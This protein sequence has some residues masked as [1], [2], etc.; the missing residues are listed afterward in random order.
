MRV[1]NE[2]A[3]RRSIRRTYV[4]LLELSTR[5]DGFGDS[6]REIVSQARE[7]APRT[8]ART[9]RGTNLGRMTARAMTTVRAKPRESGVEY[10]GVPYA[11]GAELGGQKRSST[12]MF[13]PYRGPRRGYVLGAITARP[14]RPLR[15]T[16]DGAI[17]DVLDE[18]GRGT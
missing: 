14:N 17:D 2:T 9:V 13:G 6:A 3:V 10:G 15:E 16:M 1:Q 4:A 18:W 8:R 12:R 11:W 7:R 5:P